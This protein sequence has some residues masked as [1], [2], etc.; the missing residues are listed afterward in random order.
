MQMQR[1]MF[2]KWNVSL[3]AAS[4]L[5]CIFGTYLTRSGVV[6][7][8]HSFGNHPIGN[9]FVGFLIVS[10]LLSAALLVWR[11][12]ELAPQTPLQSLVSREGAVLGGNVLLTLI[13]L[14]VLVGTTLPMLSTLVIGRS[15]TVGQPF[16]NSVVAPMGLALVALMAFGP[17]LRDGGQGGD[18]LLKSLLVPAIAALL[19]VAGLV[20]MGLREPW[21]LTAALIVALVACIVVVELMRTW[22][23]R[24]RSAKQNAVTALVAVIDG[25]HRRYGAQLTH[26]GMALAVAG[27]AGS[28]LF[29]QKQ[30]LQFG[31]GES[32]T[33]NDYT[34]TFNQLDEVRGPNYTSVVADIT[35]AAPDGTIATIR[36]QRKFFDKAEDGYSEV[37]IQSTWRQDL[38]VVLAGWES[39]GKVTAVQAII[40]PLVSWIW[41]GGIVMVCGALFCM[42]PRLLPQP[43][44]EPRR[45]AAPVSTRSRVAEGVSL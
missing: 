20:S 2:R 8:V 43:R 10:G 30:T 18:K 42:L 40:N 19:I 29:S 6:Q 12:R 7:S 36:P 27:I 24:V 25:N 16:Y 23:L 15:L 45:D 44:V 26:L 33:L 11:R 3:I 28:S 39:G 41:I 32:A 1:G 14:V 21:A 4:F 17:A 13:T 5:L 35:V 9:F 31:P 22:G 34:L 37:A 38:Y